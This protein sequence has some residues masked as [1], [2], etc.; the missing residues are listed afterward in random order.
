[1]TW[2]YRILRRRFEAVGYG[3]YFTYG[4]YEVYS[5]GLKSHCAVEP[6]G[7]TFEELGRDLIRQAEAFKLPVLDYETLE[8]VPAGES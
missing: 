7:E 1:M 6:F 4:I 2:N 5:D 3:S 8:P